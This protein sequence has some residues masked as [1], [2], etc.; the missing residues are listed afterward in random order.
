M[1]FMKPRRQLSPEVH[2]SPSLPRGHGI[3]KVASSRVL[4]LAK[5]SSKQTVSAHAAPDPI[6]IV[7]DQFDSPQGHSAGKSNGHLPSYASNDEELSESAK[8]SGLN[9]VSVPASASVSKGTLF[10]SPRPSTAARHG[11]EVSNI[12]SKLYSDGAMKDSPKRLSP[13]QQPHF[14]T[15]PASGVYYTTPTSVTASESVSS[16]PDTVSISTKR[17]PSLSAAEEVR[18]RHTILVSAIL[19]FVRAFPDIG[20][21]KAS[22]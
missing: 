11:I 16:P 9:V 17:L 21:P 10:Q 7:S 20:G 1:N 15:P 5:P 2:S 18:H 14:N 19:T 8:V 3:R 13:L 12:E 6:V 4:P 22:R